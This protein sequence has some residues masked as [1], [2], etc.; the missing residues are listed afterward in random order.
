MICIEEY[1]HKN[2]PLHERS[3]E[4]SQQ[5]KDGHNIEKKG[6]FQSEGKCDDDVNYIYQ[7]DNN[8]KYIAW[9]LP[10]FI[11][12]QFQNVQLS[13]MLCTALCKHQ[14]LQNGPWNQI[15]RHQARHPSCFSRY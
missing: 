15:G 12:E 1:L 10:D 13:L 14:T 4:N 8:S 6:T 9:S 3:A 2:V 7:K 5:I 11:P